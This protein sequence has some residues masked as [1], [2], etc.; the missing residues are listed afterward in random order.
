MIGNGLNG[1]EGPLREVFL[2]IRYFS[3]E[4]KLHF[5]QSYI[6]HGC[7]QFKTSPTHLELCHLSLDN[8]PFDPL[9]WRHMSVNA[10]QTNNTWTRLCDSTCRNVGGTFLQWRHNGRDGISNHQSHHCLLN[11]LFRRRSKKIAKLHVTGLCAGNLPVAGEFPAQMVINAE[12]V[13]IWWRHHE[14]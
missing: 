2:Y 6:Q 3:K 12:N 4:Y 8:F 9:Q 13:F 1:F 10:S 5:V 11:S 14:L 7:V